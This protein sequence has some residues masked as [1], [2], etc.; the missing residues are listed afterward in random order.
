MRLLYAL[1]L[2]ATAAA[3]RSASPAVVDSGDLAPLEVGG[4][5]FHR[6]VLANGLHALAVQDEEE[7]VTVFVVLGAGKRQETAATTGLAHLTEHA[8]YTGTP[9]TGADQHDEKV[10]A[11]GGQSNAF[12]R[13]DYTLYYDHAV[14][15]DGLDMVLI[16]EADRMRNI[17]FDEEAVLHERERLR[18]EEE[19][20][21]LVSQALNEE[22]ESVVF[23][24]HPYGAGVLD[25]GRHTLAPTLPVDTVHAF[26]DT[27]YHPDNAAVA[28]VGPLDPK[29]ALDAIER[30]F[31][32]LPRGPMR[33][34]VSTEPDVE[35]PRVERLPSHLT[36]DRWEHVWLTPAMGD[37]DRI[38]LDLLARILSRRARPDGTS[39]ASQMGTRVDRE[40][41]RVAATGPT[42]ERE[43]DELLN[44]VRTQGVDPAEVEE[45]KRLL[46]D[47]LV[48]F[49][50]RGE[51]YLS[52]AGHVATYEVFGHAD[53]L[54]KYPAIVDSITAAEVQRVARKHLD[55]AR[56]ISVVFEASGEADLP[57]PD[58][59]KLLET[60]AEEAVFAGDLP[61]AIAAYTKLLESERLSPVFRVIHLRSRG[62]IHKQMG[63]YAAAI[64]DFE[65][66]L[67]RFEWPE[68][69]DLLD[70][71][72]ALQKGSDE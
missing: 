21:Y 18:V 59:L 62:E 60:A 69:R 35:A 43:L 53:L 7:H 52:L 13:E 8:M 39:F 58:D 37:P 55:P 1:L 2:F 27:Y 20:T 68:V 38:T 41:F 3:C 9:T 44:E 48:D 36:R 26:Y 57:L 22:L 40:L 50:L 72:R 33:P 56:R 10:K 51:P 54:V 6:R 12:T 29:A 47:D 4:H 5:V 31:G 28:V 42:A 17:A 23:R 67:A 46:R 25:A 45:M 30:R 71:V 66:A 34:A 32:H 14:P 24:R 16:M 61:R 65:A 11:L 70:E 49:P 64:A 63:S 15:I 19:G